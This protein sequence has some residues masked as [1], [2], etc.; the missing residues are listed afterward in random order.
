MKKTFYRDFYFV[1][2]IFQPVELI[3][4]NRPGIRELVKI[5]IMRVGHMK[6]VC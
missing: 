2:L 3:Q 5:V 4:Q 6:Q 1:E